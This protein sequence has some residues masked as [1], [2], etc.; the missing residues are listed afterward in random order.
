MLAYYVRLRVVCIFPCEVLS[1]IQDSEKP[2]GKMLAYQARA[3]KLQKACK[4]AWK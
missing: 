1:S 3:V 4:I 2:T